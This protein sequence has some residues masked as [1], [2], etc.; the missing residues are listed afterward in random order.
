MEKTSDY[1]NDYIFA[2]KVE[3]YLKNN[4][5]PPVIKINEIPRELVKKGQS[6]A[7]KNG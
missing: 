4:I 5:P 3:E 1:E 7:K 2:L 6:S